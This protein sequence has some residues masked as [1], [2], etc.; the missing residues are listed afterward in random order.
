MPDG[1][2]VITPEGDLLTSEDIA[3]EEPGSADA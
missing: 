1:G 2:F 3:D